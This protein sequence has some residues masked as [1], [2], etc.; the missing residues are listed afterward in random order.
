MVFIAHML[1]L[2]HV[3]VESKKQVYTLQ[4]PKSAIDKVCKDKK[5]ARYD[6][7]FALELVFVAQQPK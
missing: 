1:C 3:G 2:D 6:K 7:E 5:H 4:M